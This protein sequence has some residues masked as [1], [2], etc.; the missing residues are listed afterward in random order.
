MPYTS[1]RL[2]SR[3][4]ASSL[5][6]WSSMMARLRPTGRLAR[7]EQ[8]GACQVA[9]RGRDIQPAEQAGE[10]RLVER[11]G[12]GR[13]VAQVLGHDAAVPAEQ[14]RS[15]RVKPPAA[16]GEPV[17]RGEVVVGDRRRDP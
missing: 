11:D 16:F 13:A 14:R 17:R 1:A 6:T 4:D 2:R 3:T 9:S 5:T 15:L 8:R 10:V 7:G 12:P